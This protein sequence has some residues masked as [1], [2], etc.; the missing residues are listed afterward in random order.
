L[1]G[2]IKW[3]TLSTA[4]LAAAIFLTQHPVLEETDVEDINILPY[5]L[6]GKQDAKTMLIM[7]HGFPNTFRLWDEMTK[8]LVKDYYVLNISYPNFAKEL[9]IRWGMDLDNIVG[10][11]KQTIDHVE[12]ESNH[13]YTKM[14]VAHDWGALLTYIF[15]NTYP[16]Y[17]QDIVALDVSSKKDDSL[18]AKII[19][20]L[21]QGYLRAA[22]LFGGKVGDIMTKGFISLYKAYGITSEDKE[23]VGASWNYMYYYLHK[24]YEHYQDILNNYE[25]SVPIAFFYGT[26]KK[27]MF[28]NDEFVEK[29]KGTKH[30]EVH[31]VKDGH[32]VMS[33][34]EN[35]MLIVKTIRQR[36]ARIEKK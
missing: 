10:L 15:D 12:A 29:L 2:L 3:F 28:H 26:E 27:M 36:A 35:R 9:Q 20:V 11:I 22:F 14:I 34:E 5:E 33:K 4:I 13:K 23:R 1:F 21:Y 18:K 19:T 30:C 8:N 17:V 6:S 24:R 31:G 25:P 32:W 7:L 16:K